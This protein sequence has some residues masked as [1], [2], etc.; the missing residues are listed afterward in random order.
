MPTIIG[1][2]AAHFERFS[3][4]KCVC[5]E[6]SKEREETLFALSLFF[7]F[8]FEVKASQRTRMPFGVV[9]VRESFR[10]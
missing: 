3:L 8:V 5:G 2:C 4:P 1:C 6:L 9:C 10:I 7:V